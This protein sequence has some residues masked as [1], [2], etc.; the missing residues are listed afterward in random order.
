MTTYKQP[1]TTLTVPDATTTDDDFDTLN[2]DFE[3]HEQADK[4]ITEEARLWWFNGLP[5]DTD[6]NAIGWHIKAGI[7]PY[8]DETMEGMGIQQYLV[9]HK[10]PDRNGN[11]DPKP[12]WRLRSC[13]LVIIAQRLQSS[14]EMNRSTDDRQGLAYAWGTVRDD[15]GNAVINDRGKNQGKEKRGTVLKFR[16]FVHE[17]Y[18]HGYYDWL[19]FTITGFGTDDVLKTLAEQ[20][21]VLEYYSG[22]RR[23]QSKNPV[24]PFYLFSIPLG[25]GAMKLV[26]EPPMQGSIY[27]IV[28]QVP[29]TIDKAYLK[30]H[31]IPQVLIER[32]R[33]GLVSETVVWS[34][35]ESSKIAVGRSDQGEQLALNEGTPSSAQMQISSPS[36]LHQDDPLIQQA[37]LT[38]I[39]RTF[40]GGD[41]QKVQKL[42]SDFNVSSLDQLRMSHF[43]VLVSQVQAAPQNGLR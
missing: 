1:R 21:R 10:K 24:A 25:P 28:A 8:I 20:Y 40:C 43:R 26:G 39:T 41:G 12:Y 11:T 30:R 5:T 29:A 15:Q 35:E 37:Q 4:P 3:E 19:P 17:L 6:V 33:E 9:Q 42:C 38:W 27:P 16:A 14:L 18:Q 34:I 22:L 23:A 32:L 31:L 2:I 13:S 36:T 7:N